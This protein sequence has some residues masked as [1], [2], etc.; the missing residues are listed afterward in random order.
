MLR[1]LPFCAALYLFYFGVL[2][3]LRLAAN[4]HGVLLVEEACSSFVNVAYISLGLQHDTVD[5]NP[6]AYVIFLLGS[7]LWPNPSLFYGRAVKTVFMASIPAWIFLL[8]HVR[9][10]LSRPVSLVSSLAISLLPGV[11]NFGWLAVDMSLDIPF[12]LA[13]CYFALGTSVAATALSGMLFGLA[14]I[15]YGSSLSFAPGLAVLW[16]QQFRNGNR[17][18]ALSA[19]AGVLVPLIA[20]IAWCR[21]IQSLAV[22]GALGDS[23]SATYK[24]R[25]VIADLL[26]ENVSYY[27]MTNGRAA[28]GPLWIAIFAVLATCV[29]IHFFRRD[30]FWLSVVG[31][32]I[33]VTLL[34]GG[35]PGIRRVVPMLIAMGILATQRLA[36]VAAIRPAVGWIAAAAILLHLGIET[37]SYSLDLAR[38][39]FG[40]LETSF[41]FQTAGGRNVEQTFATIRDR[42]LPVPTD[43][44]Q[45]DL[46]R[47]MGVLFVMGRAHPVVSS[48]LLLDSAN[49]IPSAIAPWAHRFERLRP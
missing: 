37:Y 7:W 47:T 41:K 13:A 43:P 32:G 42:Q 17:W 34:S 49:R 2:T 31:S 9:L 48:Q 33:A 1:L 12:A 28:L 36:Q 21:N 24:L 3:A 14:V 45:Y 25:F 4:S 38:E 19:F 29:S 8:L 26:F 44:D 10:H 46:D 40:G 27:F 30:W 18:G 35:P 6:G 39:P 23:F 22:G 16:F 5:S 15:T 11:L 20:V